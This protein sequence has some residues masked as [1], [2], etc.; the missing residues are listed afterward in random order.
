MTGVQTCAL[1]ISADKVSDVWEDIKADPGFWYNVPPLVSQEVFDWIDDIQSRHV[2]VYFV[3]ARVGLG[4]KTAST[5]W[6]LEQGVFHPT[7]V[8]ASNKGRAAHAIRATHVIDDNWE[9]TCSVVHLSEARSFILDR[10][11]NQGEH[12]NITRVKTVG[13]FLNTIEKELAA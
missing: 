8:R 2:D 5:R 4:A 10:P 11:Y 7:V 9:N 12:P 3:T 6:L 1:P 13:D